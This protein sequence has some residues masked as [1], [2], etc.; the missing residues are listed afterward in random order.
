MK[1]ILIYIMLVLGI[2]GSLAVVST[3]AYGKY[4]NNKK[5]EKIEET[6]KEYE[7]KISIDKI[8]NE[9]E[10]DVLEVVYSQ[11]IENTA[12]GKRILFLKVI[13]DRKFVVKLN[14]E[15]VFGVKMSSLKFEYKKDSNTYVFKDFEIAIDKPYIIPDSYEIYV[16]EKNIFQKMN[17]IG[18][19]EEQKAEKEAKKKIIKKAEKD[20]TNIQRAKEKVKNT[21]EQF[22]KETDSDAKVVWK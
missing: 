8:K 21:I 18:Q 11:V 1:K 19:E 14:A 16:E 7:Q 4:E 12:C 9:C 10:L 17:K 15:V 13:P 22:I 2:V 6:K 20:S 3:R 5:Q